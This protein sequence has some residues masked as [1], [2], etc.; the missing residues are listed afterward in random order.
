M[1]TSDEQF[2]ELMAHLV[3]RGNRALAQ[4]APVPPMNFLLLKNGDV[5]CSVGVADT[6]DELKRVVEAM[7]QSL[8][9]QVRMEAIVATCVASFFSSDVQMIQAGL[10]S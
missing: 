9:E 2:R 3:A 1:Q 6:P 4:H 10:E 7:Q 5:R 8:R